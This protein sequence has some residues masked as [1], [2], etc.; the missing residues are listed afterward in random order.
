MGNVIC[1]A[2]GNR[3]KLLDEIEFIL[4]YNLIA[5]QRQYVISGR[6]MK[7]EIRNQIKTRLDSERPHPETEH[8]ESKMIV[9]RNRT[10]RS[11]GMLFSM[12]YF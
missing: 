7:R 11:I 2:L 1:L 8:L 10:K 9:N 3:F 5:M 12:Y 6:R 4:E